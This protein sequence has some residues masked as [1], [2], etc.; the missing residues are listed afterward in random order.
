MLSIA[1]GMMA[2]PHVLL[3]D[4]PSL[5]LAPAI[6]NELFDILAELRDEGMTILLVD[7]IASL[8]LA[9]ADRGY[10]LES[11]RIVRAGCG[12]LAGAAIRTS[13]PRI[14]AGPRRHSKCSRHSIL[15][16]AKRALP[17]TPMPVCDIGIGGAALWRSSRGSAPTRSRTSRRP[18]CRRRLRRDPYSSGQVLHSGSLPLGAGLSRGS[19]RRGRCRQA[20]VHRGRCLCARPA[21][22]RKGDRA[23]HDPHANAC[24]G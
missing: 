16:C 24:R 5:G 7:Q 22:A 10:V 23:G 6:V 19:D 4:E 15:S 3:L 9:I 1:R 21:H 8:A 12:V 2:K 17:A 14:W 20:R 13:K 18:S 11:G